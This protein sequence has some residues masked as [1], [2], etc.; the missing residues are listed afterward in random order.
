MREK[1]SIKNYFAKL[2]GHKHWLNVC[3]TLKRLY[4]DQFLNIRGHWLYINRIS[5]YLYI[6]HIY[7]D[8]GCYSHFSR[9]VTKRCFSK[10][11][12][13]QTQTTP[14]HVKGLQYTKTSS[15][16]HMQDLT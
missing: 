1:K 14:T 10:G 8:I 12:Q 15:G 3:R 9:P 11:E 4:T 6:P 2:Q 5:L 7:L 13:K 16:N